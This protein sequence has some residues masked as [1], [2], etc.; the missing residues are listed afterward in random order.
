MLILINIHYAVRLLQETKLYTHMI[1]VLQHNTKTCLICTGVVCLVLTAAIALTYHLALIVTWGVCAKWKRMRKRK[2]KTFCTPMDR[3]N[4]IA[5]SAR[6]LDITYEPY[7]YSGDLIE[8][9]N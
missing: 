5:T 2:N 6:L 1:C 9:I 8:T 4:H 3:D 7:G